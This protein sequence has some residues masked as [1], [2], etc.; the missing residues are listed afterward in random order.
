MAEAG[1]P[2]IALIG[3]PKAGSSSLF[4]WLS[5]HPA[6]IGSRP[7]ETF[8][9]MDPTHPLYRRHGASVDSDGV[10]AYRGFYP[11]EHGARLRLDGSVHAFYQRNAMETF[12]KGSEPRLVVVTL[13]C[14]ARRIYSSFQFTKESLGQV[15]NRLS[16]AGY[17][18]A[19]LSGDMEPIRTHY[20]SADSFWLASKELELGRYIE[21][22]E[23]W[24]GLIGADRLA[25]TTLDHMREEPQAV[26][27]GLMRRLGLTATPYAGY[28]FP[29]RNES[30]RIRNKRVHRYARRL[31]EHSGVPR[32]GIRRMYSALQVR[33]DESETRKED[34]EA[35]ARLREYFAPWN[36]RL[37]RRYGIDVDS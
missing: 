35:L 24:Q 4:M 20:A 22:L 2:E 11:S 23:P 28:E 5:R 29:R 36:E 9:F 19:L 17:V 10:E 37:S 32:W 15:D 3:W 13:R 7:K 8:F 6:I 25:I 30:V 18:N 21:W 14:P 31:A 27:T 1:V 16:F 26:V 12:G 34:K 33:R